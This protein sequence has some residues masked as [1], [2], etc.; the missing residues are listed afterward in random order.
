MNVVNVHKSTLLSTENNSHHIAKNNT[1]N[2]SNP[3]ATLPLKIFKQ[4]FHSFSSL[5]ED[6]LRKIL[7]ARS[8]ARVFKQYMPNNV[9]FLQLYQPQKLQFY[10]DKLSSHLNKNLFSIDGSHN[11]LSVDRLEENYT[12]TLK[13]TIQKEDPVQTRLCIEKLGD[14]YL[15]KGTQQTLLQAA[16]LYNY[17]L[18]TASLKGQESIKEKLSKVEFL[19]SKA[20]KGKPVDISITK[21]QFEDNRREL[22]KFRQEIEEKIQ[23]LGSDPSSEEVRMLYQE[24]A[25]WMKVFFKSLVGQAQR[26]LGAAPCEYA[27]LGFGSL[28]RK[29]MTPYSDL[30]FGILMQEDTS[31]NRDYFRRLTN[32]LH[33]KVINLGETILP[34]LNIPCIKK[35]NFF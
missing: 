22:K 18:H 26:G 29:E 11:F 24:I 17:T 32:L 30:E 4:I 21:K 20:C 3:L 16:G 25:Q 33:L 31:A 6:E 1:F 9:K 28:A 27:M 15:I 2:P 12:H 23:A 13:L 34:A 7:D 35:A 19:L 8:C 10:F 14:I 5:T